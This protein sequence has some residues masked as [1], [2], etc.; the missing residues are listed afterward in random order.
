MLSRVPK[1]KCGTGFGRL[2]NKILVSL[3]QAHISRCGTAQPSNKIAIT[4]PPQLTATDLHKLIDS[5]R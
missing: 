4:H 2:K 5:A 1:P 3:R